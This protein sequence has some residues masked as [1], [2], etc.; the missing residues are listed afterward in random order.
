[1]TLRLHPVSQNPFV[2]RIRKVFGEFN[3]NLKKTGTKF[4]KIFG[5]EKYSRSQQF[6]YYEGGGNHIKSFTSFLLGISTTC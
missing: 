1:V 3:W 4:R 2:K 6:V 5:V